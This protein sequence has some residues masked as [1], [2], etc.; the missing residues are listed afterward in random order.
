[1]SG[2]QV[3]MVTMG[4][5]VIVAGIGVIT[6][7]RGLARAISE[8]SWGRFGVPFR[9]RLARMGMIGAGAI[10]VVIGATVIVLALTVAGS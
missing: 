9:P 5:F 2:Q 4:C 6:T 8:A 3:E 7:S 10:G 1:M